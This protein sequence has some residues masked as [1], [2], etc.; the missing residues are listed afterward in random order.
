MRPPREEDALVSEFSDA[1]GNIR[2][3]YSWQDQAGN[4]H[5]ASRVV[6]GE[7]DETVAQF[8]LRAEELALEQ[9][10]SVQGAVAILAITIIP[11]LPII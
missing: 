5:E 9:R 8:R 7:A 6:P 4:V 11:M 3:Y 1:Q 10:G 2:F